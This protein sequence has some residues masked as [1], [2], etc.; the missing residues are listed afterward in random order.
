MLDHLIIDQVTAKEPGKQSSVIRRR[1]RLPRV[2]TPRIP[3]TSICQLLSLRHFSEPST[4]R[5]RRTR[6]RFLA[7]LVLGNPV[8]REERLLDGIRKTTERGRLPESHLLRIPVAC[9]A[10]FL[11]R[12]H[13]QTRV[14]IMTLLTNIVTSPLGPSEVHAAEA[15]PVPLRHQPNATNDQTK[16]EGVPTRRRSVWTTLKK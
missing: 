15:R 12:D 11:R 3:T 13:R 1:Y 2:D 7:F 9:S 10:D 4:L 5:L 8:Y 6:T 16:D 14:P